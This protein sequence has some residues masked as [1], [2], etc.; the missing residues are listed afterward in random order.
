MPAKE[1]KLESVQLVRELRIFG[2]QVAQL[3]CTMQDITIEQLAG[4]SV[5]VNKSGT[6]KYIVIYPAG[7]AAAVYVPVEK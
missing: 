3:S 7:I 6:D 1:F 5:R 4:G 2:H